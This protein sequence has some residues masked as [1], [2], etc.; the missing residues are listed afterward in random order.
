MIDLSVCTTCL[1]GEE[2]PGAMFFHALE[3]SLHARQDIR[4]RP[5]ECMSVCKRPC[6]VAVSQP[7]KWTYIIGDLDASNDVGALLDYIDVYAQSEHGT[8]PLKDRPA[9]IRRG[10]IARLPPS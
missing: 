6:T 3:A 8:P 2:R 10:T 5:V 9:A 1:N 7:G 4:L